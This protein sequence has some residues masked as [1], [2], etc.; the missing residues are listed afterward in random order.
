MSM[1]DV[2]VLVVH[3]H[4][5]YFHLAIR[6]RLAYNEKLFHLA[7]E[8]LKVRIIVYVRELQAG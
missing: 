6:L 4:L 3:L 1:S 5:L 7:C 2:H 8:G